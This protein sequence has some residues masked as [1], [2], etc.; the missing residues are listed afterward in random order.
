VIVIIDWNKM[1]LDGYLTDVS[2][3]FD[4]SKK[5]EAF[6]FYTIK[7]DGTDE[8]SISNAIDEAK[9]VTDSAVC[10]VMDSVKANGVPYYIDR[11]DNHGPKFNAEADAAL[12][13]TIAA[14]EASLSEKGGE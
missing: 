10:I 7:A 2:N 5:M 9:T 8:E 3:P 6:G 13:E 4:L 12:A 11:T 1:Q 14:L